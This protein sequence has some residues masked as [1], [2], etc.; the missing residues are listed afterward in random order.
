[1]PVM[2]LVRTAGRRINGVRVGA[3]FYAVIVVIIRCVV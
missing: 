1:M 2:A 3:P